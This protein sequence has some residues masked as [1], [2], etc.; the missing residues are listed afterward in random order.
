MADG[1][2]IRVGG[3]VRVDIRDAQVLEIKGPDCMPG[4]RGGVGPSVGWGLRLMDRGNSSPDTGA[5]ELEA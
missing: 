3:W 2:F 1:S 5:P 4:L